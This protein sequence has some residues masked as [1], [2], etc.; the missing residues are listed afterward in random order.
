MKIQ[1]K[2]WIILQ[3]PRDFPLRKR[4]EKINNLKKKK[5]RFMM[6]IHAHDR[7]QKQ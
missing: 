5:K 6:K 7:I 2:F 3:Y 4:K 1:R